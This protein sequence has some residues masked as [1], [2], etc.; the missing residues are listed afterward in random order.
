MVMNDILKLIRESNSIAITFHCSPD[1]DSLGSSLALMLGI[2]SL[3]KNAYIVSKETIPELYSFLPSSEEI[4]GKSH[5][6]KNDT[7]CLIVLDCGD[8]ER[9]NAI[10]DFKNRSYSIINIDHHIS[11]SLYG[12]INYVDTNSSAVGEIIYQMLQLLG[13]SI[14][15]SMAECL[16][17][18]I[19]SDTGSF[20][21]SSTTSVTHSIAG[22]LINTHIDFSKIHRNVY[23][24]KKYERLKLYG[25]VLDSMELIH[26]TDGDLCLMYV[27]Q[28]MLDE[29][30]IESS[31]DTSDVISMGIEIAQVEV[32]ILFKESEEGTKVSLR[33]KN[34]IDVRKIAELFGGGGHI[35]ASGLYLKGKSID[36][37]K[38]LIIPTVEKELIK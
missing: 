23:E 19:I 12:D 22:D 8:I 5:N 1:G 28:D 17:T 32:A 18:S 4:N 2:R 16:Y 26:V 13:V 15:K 6:I 31:T 27:T 9:I 11:N 30:K 36:E 3:N 10:V 33:S 29:I 24:N 20:K 38:E 25:K 14:N 35:R 37:A 34:I 7:Q 21:Y